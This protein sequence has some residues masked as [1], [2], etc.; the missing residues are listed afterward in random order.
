MRVVQRAAG[1]AAILAAAPLL[2]GASLNETSSGYTYFN[3]PGADMAQQDADLAACSIFAGTTVQPANVPVV[4]SGNPA[5]DLIAFSIVAGA[6]LEI[7]RRRGIPINVED[8]MVV[9]GWRIVRIDQAEGDTLRALDTRDRQARISGWVGAV[10]PHGDIVRVFSNEALRAD[11]S[12]FAPAVAVGTPLYAA[13]NARAHQ[14]DAQLDPDDPTASSSEPYSVKQVRRLKP[15]GEEKPPA[16]AGLIVV[17][18]AGE[19]DM[20]LVLERVDK[21]GREIIDHDGAQF[22]IPLKSA[23]PETADGQ[24]MIFAAAPGHWR[25][26]AVEVLAKPRLSVNF[27]LGGPSFDLA[28][29]DAV[30]LGYFNG[31][32]RSIEP[33]MDAARAKTA[34]VAVTSAQLR[35][36]EWT[37]GAVGRCHGEYLYALEFPGRPFADGYHLGSKALPETPPR[38]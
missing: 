29:G 20:G 4:V 10:A 26:A 22:T 34:A 13:A 33:D 24:T 16:G 12:M 6:S 27:C 37:N 18:V 35:P 19:G 31:A 28:R 21:N 3:K 7:A 36:A 8:C 15:G 2:T 1:L 14:P 11:M 25:L 32:S 5:A 23:T 9:K 17:D 38:P 30:Y